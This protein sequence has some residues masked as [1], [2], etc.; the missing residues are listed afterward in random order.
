MSQFSV[1]CDYCGKKSI[2]DKN[3]PGLV[4]IPLSEVPG[5]NKKLNRPPMFKCP[6]CGR[7]ITM[8]KVKEIKKDVGNDKSNVDKT[9]FIGPSI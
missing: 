5:L 8:K 4:S 7:G 1:Y 6:T 3:K 2:I 9:G